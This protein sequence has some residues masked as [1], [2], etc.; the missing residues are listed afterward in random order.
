MQAEKAL[1]GWNISGRS[2]HCIYLQSENG[3]KVKLHT[4]EAACV[5]NP[6]IKVASHSIMAS[7]LAKTDVRSKYVRC[8]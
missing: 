3:I 2:G 4:A 6:E 5:N 1:T 7:D 8:M